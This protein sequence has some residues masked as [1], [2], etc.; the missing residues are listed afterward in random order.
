MDE[1]T[2]YSQIEELNEK[3]GIPFGIEVLD[4]RH[5]AYVEEPDSYTGEETDEVRL[6]SILFTP[7]LT[8]AWKRRTLLL[9]PQLLKSYKK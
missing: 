1:G 7:S 9:L 2:L 8:G 3:E 5:C 4:S 6:S